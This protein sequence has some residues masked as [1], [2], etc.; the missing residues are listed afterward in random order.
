MN[1]VATYKLCYLK[2]MQ[3][4]FVSDNMKQNKSHIVYELVFFDKKMLEPVAEI[5]GWGRGGPPGSS[6]GSVT[7]NLFSKDSCSLIL[8]KDH[9]LVSEL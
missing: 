1:Y 8:L 6:P 5:K 3:K 2:S 7:G 9:F 4:T